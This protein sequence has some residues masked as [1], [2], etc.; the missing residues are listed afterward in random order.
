MVNPP[1]LSYIV[2]TA[3][4]PVLLATEGGG[5]EEEG[6]AARLAVCIQGKEVDKGATVVVEPDE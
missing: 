2:V 5:V 6:A 4:Q 1:T 3:A